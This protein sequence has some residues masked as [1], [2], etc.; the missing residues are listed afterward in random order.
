ME[1]T[2]WQAPFPEDSG[3]EAAAQLS[4][5]KRTFEGPGTTFLLWDKRIALRCGPALKT[6]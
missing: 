2:N 4:H 3:P 6:G 5:L 1:L